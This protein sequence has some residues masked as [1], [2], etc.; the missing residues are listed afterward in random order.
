M[1]SP[2]ELSFLPDDYLERKAQRRAFVLYGVVSAVVLGAI[3]AGVVSSEKAT[4]AA[5]ARRAEV[6]RRMV[7]AARQI[8]QVNKLHEQQRK[9]VQHAELAASL[10]EKVPRSRVLAQLTNSLPAGCSLLDFALESRQRV[11]APAL[12]F[13]QKKAALDAQHKNDLAG[14]V[15]VPKFDVTMKLTG[16]TDTDVQ[17]AQYIAKLNGCPEFKDVNLLISEPYK[18][19]NDTLRKFQIEL[20]LDPNADVKDGAR[21]TRTAAVEIS[22]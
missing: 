5:E 8:E 15:E 2:N 6:S 11:E 13:D 14:H 10:V 12:T 17:V 9:I 1:S 16:I 19:G 18:Q 22:K 4:S 3:A 7:E 21:A 20:T